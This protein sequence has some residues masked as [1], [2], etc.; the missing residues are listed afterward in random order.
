MPAL[1]MFGK[2]LSGLKKFNKPRADGKR[3]TLSN[4][5]INIKRSA[6]TPI[7]RLNDLDAEEKSSSSAL[8]SNNDNNGDQLGPP[9]QRMMSIAITR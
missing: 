7:T 6:E 2:I 1:K 8:S 3:Q 5:M 9:I 4:L